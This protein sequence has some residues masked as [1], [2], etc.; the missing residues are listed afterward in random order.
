MATL[1][2]LRNQAGLLLAI[3]IFVALAAFI[4]GDLLKSGSSMIRGK[5]LEIAQIDGESIEYP[6]FQERFNEISNI[7]K[8][9]NQVNSLDEAA[10]K[11]ILDQTWENLIQEIVMADVYEDLAINISSEEMFDMVQGKN[12]HPIIVQVFGDPQTGI[13]DKANVIQFLKYIQENPTAPQRASWINIEKEI[14]KAK[15]TTKYTDLVAK[16]LY[17][18]T[19]QAR[20][21]IESK[22]KV[23]SLKFIQKKLS[24]VPDSLVSVSDEDLT[25]YYNKNIDAYQ[26]EAQKSITYVT[27]NIVPS[28]DDD[29]ATLRWVNETKADFQ[30]AEDNVQFVNMN[31]DTRFEDVYEK[32]DELNTQLSNWAFAANI[33]DI[34]GPYKE[35]NVYKLAK[36]N[37]TKMLPDSVKASHILI[38]AENANEAQIA[39]AIIDSLQTLI[40][41]GASF[42]QLAKDNSQDGSA[43]SGGDLG[44]FKR[45]QMVAPFEKAAFRA[46]KNEVVAVQTKFG[47]HLI[48]TTAKGKT[49]KHVQLAIV[50]REVIPSTT[51]YQKLYTEASKFAATSKDLDGFNGL[52]A[53]QKLSPRIASISETDRQIPGIGASRNLIRTAFNTTE[54]GELVIGDDKSPVYEIDNKFVVTAVVSE[55]I[56][57]DSPFETVKSAVELA[58]I[59]E[60]KKALL[61]DQFNAA[62]AATIEETAQ[63]LGLTVESAEGFNFSYGS[64]NAIGYEPVLNGAATAL[65]V[66]TL[67]NPVEGRNGV[68]F[69]ELTS[70][71]SPEAANVETE[72]LALY[73]SASFSVST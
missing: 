52:S 55:K 21:S 9:N 43:T 68:Y 67:S 6:E 46:N 8:T 3:V 31:G 59:K 66:N 11:Q 14:L 47:F 33:N 45:G 2:K 48:K 57:G 54:V 60:K 17:A 16:S 5:Q 61:T 65:E 53:E 39:S 72:K 44:W 25:N 1:Q 38:R 13:V 62:K 69:I 58:V 30:K 56:K 22:D 26:Q 15:K 32:E 28:N 7:Y 42:A 23:A 71:T 20:Q 37:T 35:G 70:I 18:N 12:L 36:L 19:L 29:Q 49:S 50:D 24:T 27:F 63:N 51:T 40:K 64:V 4:L 34:Y 73:Q 10:Y 41:G